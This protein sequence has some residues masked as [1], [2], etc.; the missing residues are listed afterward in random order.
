MTA[1]FLPK[2]HPLPKIDGRRF[3]NAMGQF[4]TGVTLVTARA[5]RGESIGVTVNSF[6]SV[7]LDPP[8]VL[9]CLG[10]DARTLPIILAAR[11]FAVN[12]LGH[13]HRSVA[14]RF[15]VDPWSWGGLDTVSWVT[16]APILRDAPAALDCQLHAT[17]DGGDHVI[18][19]GRVVRLEVAEDAQPLGYYRGRYIAIDRR[20]HD[21]DR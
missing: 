9:F 20:R 19:I 2:I 5:E 18:L 21:P 17:H 10:R 12:V 3:R 6:T 16:G 14:E 13:E 11:S 15:A 7:S 4:V 8:L 1:S